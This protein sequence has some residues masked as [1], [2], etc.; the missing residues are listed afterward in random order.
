ME[1]VLDNHKLIIGFLLFVVVCGT[2]FAIGFMEGK[3]QAIPMRGEQLEA[4]PAAPTSA[5]E[6]GAI[7]PSGSKPIED[8][9]V[10]DPLDWYTNVQDADDADAKGGGQAASSTRT[11]QKASEPPSRSPGV[12]VTYTVQVGAFRQL[13]EAQI[14]E[15]TLK[16]KG[17]PCFIE[18]PKSAD[19]FYLVKVGKFSSRAEAKVM[20]LRLQKDGFSSFIKPN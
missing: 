13:Q 5:S 8:R 15:E 9:S 7:T 18:S 16:D 3:R 6:T 19:Q 12:A 20:Q 4:A 1:I 2:F 11:P 10:R 14:R 17:Y